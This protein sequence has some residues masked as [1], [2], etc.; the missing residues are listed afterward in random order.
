MRG[1]P[2]ELR[3]E[4]VLLRQ[5]GDLLP[6]N[7]HEAVVLDLGQIHLLLR[8]P[9]LKGIQGGVIESSEIQ[10]LQLELA[11]RLQVEHIFRE[12]PVRTSGERLQPRRRG[13][14]GMAEEFLGNA[15]LQNR[16]VLIAQSRDDPLGQRLVFAIRLHGPEQPRQA[17]V[18]AA[19][20]EEHVPAQPAAQQL[21]KLGS[22]L[23]LT[24][25]QQVVRYVLLVQVLEQRLKLIDEVRPHDGAALLIDARV[26]DAHELRRPREG[27]VGEVLAVGQR[28]RGGWGDVEL[29]GLRRIA[30]LIAQDAGTGERDREL[31]LRGPEQED[32]LEVRMTAALDRADEHLVQLRRDER[33]RHLREGGRQQAEVVLGG[34]LLA[35]EDLDQGIEDVHERVEELPVLIRRGEI[36]AARA[37]RLTH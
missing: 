23:D 1:T 8:Q 29:G 2:D 10:R 9:L 13:M 3:E 31:L 19:R 15:R 33:Q 28:L 30:V 17:V 27:D 35:F 34:H 22:V 18:G 12:I 25:L 36:A 26:A 32:R 14:Q 4:R 20:R 6:Q 21:A 37:H 11:P 7:L 16:P 24:E 5:L